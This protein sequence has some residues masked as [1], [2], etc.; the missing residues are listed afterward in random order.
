MI[1][2]ISEAQLGKRLFCWMELIMIMVSLMITMI[3]SWSR[4]SRWSSRWRRWQSRWGSVG[5][6]FK[7]RVAGWNLS[8]N[9]DHPSS[10]S[11]MRGPLDRYDEDFYIRMRRRMM[12]YNSFITAMISDVKT[13]RSDRSQVGLS[14]MSRQM[15]ACTSP[16]PIGKSISNPACC[17]FPQPIKLVL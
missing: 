8:V 3:I 17:I 15:L 1:R 16:L 5:T 2:Q 13:R 4:W 9:S 10:L 12:T 11:L 7:G 14:F 6:G